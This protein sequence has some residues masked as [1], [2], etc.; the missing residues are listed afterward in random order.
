MTPA[1][2]RQVD[3]LAEAGYIL[4]IPKGAFMRSVKIAITI[5]VALLERLDQL[6]EE[7][8]FPSR[9]RAVQEAIRDK[10]KRMKRNR[11]ASECANLDAA[12]EKA[13]ADDGL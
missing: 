9:S 5:D 7:H 11:F 12:E 3:G 10:L 1:Q 2:S 6:I 13:L 8:R 4:N